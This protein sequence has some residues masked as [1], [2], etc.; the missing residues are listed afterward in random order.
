MPRPSHRS[1]V[2]G[3]LNLSFC[4]CVSSA[5][6]HS[7]AA[8]SDHWYAWKHQLRINISWSIFCSWFC[9]GGLAIF[10]EKTDVYV[11]VSM[12]AR[13]SSLKAELLPLVISLMWIFLSPWQ[14]RKSR[15]GQRA[16]LAG[17]ASQRAIAT[18]AELL[19]AMPTALPAKV[20]AVAVT[21]S[22][23]S[24]IPITVQSFPEGC[25]G[26]GMIIMALLWGVKVN[27]QRSYTRTWWCSIC[28]VHRARSSVTSHPVFVF[29]CPC[30]CWGGV[31]FFFFIWHLHL[32]LLLGAMENNKN[33][34]SVPPDC[35]PQVLGSRLCCSKA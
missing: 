32:P 12:R 3:S 16:A 27:L 5:R 22:W 30:M 35:F 28:H 33:R 6:Y 7:L 25:D 1:P 4:P 14:V 15:T 23:W 31:D 26:K 17:D 13:A 11:H 20:K 24:L 18:P 21:A 8:G 10:L 19:Y 34:N 9:P 2:G 29:V